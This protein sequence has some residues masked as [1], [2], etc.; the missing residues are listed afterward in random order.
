MN[1][2]NQILPK[3]EYAEFICDFLTLSFRAHKERIHTLARLNPFWI[4]FYPKKCGF[5]C[6]PMLEVFEVWIKIMYLSIPSKGLAEGEGYVLWK[7][8]P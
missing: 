6:I 8:T 5:S 2:T 7:K 3:V 1:T 4:T